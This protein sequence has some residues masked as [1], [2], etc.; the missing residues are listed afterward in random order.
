MNTGSISTA[1]DAEI[2]RDLVELGFIEEYGW[3]PE[4]IAS[5]P[6]KWIQKHNYMRRVKY[7]A[8]ETRRQQQQF[9]TQ[10]AA[11]MKPGSKTWQ[12]VS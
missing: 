3:T 11:S 9:K 2:M 5:L 4:Y 12:T 8:Q 6:Y 7:A 10:A 1:V